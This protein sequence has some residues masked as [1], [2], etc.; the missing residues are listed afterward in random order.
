MRHVVYPGFM[1]VFLLSVSN[2]GQ[3]T[4]GSVKSMKQAVRGNLLPSMYVS[5]ATGLTQGPQ[6][7]HRRIAPPPP[8]A[9]VGSLHSNLPP[10]KVGFL[11]SIT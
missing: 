9:P 6:P 5:A 3:V 11:R 7:D 4:M 1:S 10:D 8:V 2:Q